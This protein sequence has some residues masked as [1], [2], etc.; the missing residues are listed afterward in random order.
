MPFFIA[1]IISYI[2]NPV[3]TIL[4]KRKV[5]RTIAVLIDLWYVYHIRDGHYHEY[6]ADVY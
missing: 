6:D 2:L 1:V 5:P 3:V 4:N